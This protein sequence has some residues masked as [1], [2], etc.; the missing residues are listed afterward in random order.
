[1]LMAGLDGIQRR[2]D[3]GQPLDKRIYALTPAELAEESRACRLPS[4][5]RSQQLEE[6][7]RVPAQG[8]RIHERPD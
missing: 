6:G 4:R 3:P 2:L 5:W 1:M 8:R 7:S